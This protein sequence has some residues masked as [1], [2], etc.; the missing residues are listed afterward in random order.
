MVYHAYFLGY[1]SIHDLDEILQI[2]GS[3]C[4]NLAFK[5]LSFNFQKQTIFKSLNL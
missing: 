5:L 4:L 2:G 3:G 1:Q